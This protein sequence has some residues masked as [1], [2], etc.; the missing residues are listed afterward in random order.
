MWQICNT[1]GEVMRRLQTDAALRELLCDKAL[2]LRAGEIRPLGER[3]H[4]EHMF[5]LFFQCVA[6]SV[7]SFRRVFKCLL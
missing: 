4:G 3:Q 6:L 1:I 2:K 7:Y 5:P